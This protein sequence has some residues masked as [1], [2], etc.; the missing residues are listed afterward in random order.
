MTGLKKS[1][2]L[3]SLTTF[4]NDV[5]KSRTISSTKTMQGSDI[6]LNP[7]WEWRSTFD[8]SRNTRISLTTT[9]K[10]GRIFNLFEMGKKQWD[11]ADYTQTHASSGKEVPRHKK[12]GWRSKRTRRI[13]S[14]N[15]KTLTG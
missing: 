13:H 7:H 14:K 15:P 5:G 10:D 9:G 6:P 11:E 3:T 1:T 12:L 8:E 4:R 2:S